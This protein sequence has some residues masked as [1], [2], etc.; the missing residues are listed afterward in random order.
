MEK[1]N[2]RARAYGGPLI[3]YQWVW[4]SFSGKHRGNMGNKFYELSWVMYSKQRLI[5][6]NEMRCLVKNE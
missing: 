5:L 4:S 1:K 6:S 2:D 3:G